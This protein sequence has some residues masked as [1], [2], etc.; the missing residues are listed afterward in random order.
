MGIGI[1]RDLFVPLYK[2]AR[3][4]AYTEYNSEE[5][6]KECGTAPFNPRTVLGQVSQ[7]TS[8]AP[9]NGPATTSEF[10]LDKTPYTKCGLRQ[11]TNRALTFIKNATEGDICN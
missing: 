8:R 4:L 3:A 9:P 5:A 11:Q 10:L 2:K 6:F 7:P 1:N